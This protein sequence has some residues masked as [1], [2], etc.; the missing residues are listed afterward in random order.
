MKDKL[1]FDA[2]AQRFDLCRQLLIFR[3]AQILLAQDQHVRLYIKH[4]R[5]LLLKRMRRK[6]PVR[7]TNLFIHRHNR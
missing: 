6:R 3:L 1:R 4:A 2:F 7:H 5:D